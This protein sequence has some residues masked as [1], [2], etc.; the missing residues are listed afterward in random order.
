M[1]AN[2]IAPMFSRCFS[3]LICPLLA[4]NDPFLCFTET[5]KASERNSQLFAS[6]STHHPVFCLSSFPHIIK[7]VLFPHLREFPLCHLWTL[8]SISFPL[9][10]IFNLS[11]FFFP[12]SFSIAFQLLM[13]QEFPGSPLVRTLCFHCCVF[14]PWVRELR[15]CKPTW[16]KKKYERKWILS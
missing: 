6:K 14:N 5:W 11:L 9:S 1:F 15:L 4:V 2:F 8:T 7:K 12:C 13:I 10:C 3:V 16:Q